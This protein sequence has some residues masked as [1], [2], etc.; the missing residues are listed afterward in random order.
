[1]FKKETKIF[2]FHPKKP[3]SFYVNFL[4]IKKRKYF[5]FGKIDF[6]GYMR[7]RNVI[8]SKRKHIKPKDALILIVLLI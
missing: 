4:E 7:K 3:P 5:H 6:G 2:F 1:M 8:Y